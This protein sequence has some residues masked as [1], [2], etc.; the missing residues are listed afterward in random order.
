MYERQVNKSVIINQQ[1]HIEM[2]MLFSNLDFVGCFY[3]LAPMQA[4]GICKFVSRLR[5][6]FLLPKRVCFRQPSIV[7][8]LNPLWKSFCPRLLEQCK[9]IRV[10]ITSTVLGMGYEM[11]AAAWDPVTDVI[12][13]NHDTA[14][15]ALDQKVSANILR[16]ALGWNARTKMKEWFE[17][18]LCLLESLKS[19]YMPISWIVTSLQVQLSS[20]KLVIKQ[21]WC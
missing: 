20:R 5:D 9:F 15:V 11:V 2:L 6:S 19:L 8:S 17:E 3:N 14:A 1:S 21:G 13:S 4:V 16:S 7:R 10:F 18:M 12:V